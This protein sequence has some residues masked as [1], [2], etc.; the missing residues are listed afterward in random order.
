MKK[1][2]T[3]VLA[4]L[5]MLAL[6]ACSASENQE[7]SD[8]HEET[9]SGSQ[10]ES[11]ESEEIPESE[12]EAPGYVELP[13]EETVFVDD[14]TCLVKIS[15]SARVTDQSITIP[16][17]WENRSEDTPYSISATSSGNSVYVNGLK[18][19]S[20][21]M[22]AYL[23]PGESST[24][25]CYIY[26]EELAE[27]GATEY[28]DIALTLT[29]FDSAEYTNICEASAH[30]YPYGEEQATVF[31]RE[32]QPADQV[33]AEN[34]SF[35]L[36]VTGSGSVN[37]NGGYSIPIYL[38][39]K[40]DHRMKFSA[41]DSMVNDV[42]CSPDTLPDLAAHTSAF[43]SLHWS[44]S[45]LEGKGIT[46]VESVTLRLRVLEF[47]NSDIAAETIYDEMLSVEL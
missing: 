39:N 28:T 42:S 17:Q 38:V 45:Y 25:Y 47:A 18:A 33:L 23:N 32:A 43:A 20:N 29:V 22:P 30:I 21:F 3:L 44:E 13:L 37:E 41:M 14:E 19:R 31:T 6:L 11:E 7:S 1:I 10:M 15:G 16:I 9:G 4:F 5:L 2:W 46:T 36:I 40:T 24:D 12:T 27:G 34:E 35:A 26:P 8:G